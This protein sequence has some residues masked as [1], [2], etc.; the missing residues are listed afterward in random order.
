MSKYYCHECEYV[1]EPRTYEMY[2]ESVSFTVICC[3]RCCAELKHCNE[4]EDP[5]QEAAGDE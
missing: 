4:I 2:R 5:E 3:S 1:G